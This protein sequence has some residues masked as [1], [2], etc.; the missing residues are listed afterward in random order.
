[1]TTTSIPSLEQTLDVYFSA[2]NEP[3]RTARLELVGQAFSDEAHY[4]DPLADVRGHDGI[5]DMIEAVRAQY[6]GATLRRTSEIDA[7]HEVARFSWDASDAGGE[8]IVAGIDVATVAADGRLDGI[9][10]FFG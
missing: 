5:V 1:M 6:P 8:V 9:T 10:G 2:W 4:V 7:H 3:D